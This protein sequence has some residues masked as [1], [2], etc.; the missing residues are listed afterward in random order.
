M[1]GLL[2]KPSHPLVAEVGKPV[3]WWRGSPCPPG[4]PPP[5]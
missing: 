3:N 4:R 1:M 5:I 2:A